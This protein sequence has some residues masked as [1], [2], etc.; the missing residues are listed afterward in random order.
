MPVDTDHLERCPVPGDAVAEDSAQALLARDGK[1]RLSHGLAR[2]CITRLSLV[3]VTGVLLLVGLELATRLFSHVTPPLLLNDPLVGTTYLPGFSGAVYI[4]EADREVWL[5]FNREGTRGP[6]VPYEKTTGVTRIAVVGDSMI[7]AVATDEDKTLVRRLEERLNQQAGGRRYEVLNFGISGSSTGQELVLYRERVRK[8]HPD[9]VIC[10]FCVVNDLGDNCTRLT[11]NR[12]RIYFDVDEADRLQQVPMLPG[13]VQLNSWLNRHSRFYVWQK[14]ATQRAIDTVRHKAIQ[15]AAT[16]GHEAPSI[17]SGGLGI[18]CTEP[19][20]DV[21][22]AWRV[23]EKL[24][25]T[26]AA[27]VRADGGEFLLA[28]I[29]SGLQVCD[30]IWPDVVK[31]AGGFPMDRENPERVLSEIAEQI[32]ALVITMSEQ[33]RASS[34][35]H[36]KSYPDE[37]LFYDGIGHMNDHGNDLAAQAICAAVTSHERLSA[38]ERGAAR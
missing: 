33:F 25:Q 21:A 6:D 17:D 37:W 9:L 11:S 30:D 4:P 24:V 22:Y 27:E 26:L 13:R 28:V 2:R 12:G 18:F 14:G 5:R 32:P 23:T 7:A 20:G 36:S 19:T 8:Y 38:V 16:I 1:R 34:P 3:L 15:W 31:T 29:P 10:A 35:H